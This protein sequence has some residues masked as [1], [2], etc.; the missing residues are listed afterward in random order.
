MDINLKESKYT[1]YNKPR[2]NFITRERLDRVLVNWKWLHIHQNVSLK[3]APTISSD[4]CALIL[5]T[6]PRDQIKREFRFEAFWTEH[7]EC[8]KVIRRSWQQDDRNRNCWNQFIRKR[9][10][11]K[12]DLIEWSRRKFKRADKEIEKKEEK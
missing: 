3:D 7:E 9:S 11:C 10:R 2:N 5:E 6:Q 8:E 12:R 1:W 4:H